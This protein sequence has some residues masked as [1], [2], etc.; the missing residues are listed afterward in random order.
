LEFD[1]SPDAFKPSTRDFRARTVYDRSEVDQPP[2]PV[3][4]KVPGFNLSL[5]K[6]R[7]YAKISLLYIVNTKGTVEALS[8]LGSG[9]EEF[10][11]VVMDGVRHWRFK[12]AI[13]NGNRVDCWVRQNVVVK[14]DPTASPFD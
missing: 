10:D 14:A 11:K 7:R 5:M 1:F 9:G 8:M 4:K 2:I 13:K 12:P 6:N 3:Y